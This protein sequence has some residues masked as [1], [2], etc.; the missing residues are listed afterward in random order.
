MLMKGKYMKQ[1]K[2]VLEKIGIFDGVVKDWKSKGLKISYPIKKKT[3]YFKSQDGVVFVESADKYVPPLTNKET[4]TYTKYPEKFREDFLKNVR[5]YFKFH[6]FLYNKSL[7]VKKLTN[8]KEQLAAYLSLMY[9]FLSAMDHHYYHFDRYLVYQDYPQT[10]VGYWWQRLKNIYY[11][12]FGEKVVKNKPTP[13]RFLLT[14]ARDEKTLKEY[15]EK[16]VPKEYQEFNN[17]L[18]ALKIF[19]TVQREEAEII[20][21]YPVKEDLLLKTGFGL[22]NNICVLTKEAPNLVNRKKRDVILKLFESHPII[23]TREL[24]LVPQL[25][26][27]KPE[28]FFEF[29]TEIK[30][31]L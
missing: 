16:L 14:I 17:I 27:F 2:T 15:K 26:A 19:E 4:I 5:F 8:H 22:W 6:T 1:N 9:L 7:N 12:T 24:L 10:P 11:E 30:R 31:W 29:K 13:F 21:G 3:H 18:N 20:S 23:S 25:Q 28:I